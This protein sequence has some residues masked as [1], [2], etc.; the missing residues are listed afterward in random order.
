[1]RIKSNDLKLRN[2]FLLFGEHN[3]ALQCTMKR[4]CC[5]IAC[6][7]LLADSDNGTGFSA[8]CCPHNTMFCSALLFLFLDIDS[9]VFCFIP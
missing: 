3:I 6:V 4:F 2:D 5:I 9:I 1:M 8:I 7:L